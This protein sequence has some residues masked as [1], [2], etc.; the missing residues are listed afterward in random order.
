MVNKLRWGDWVICAAVL[1]LAGLAAIPFLFH[2]TSGAL[3]CEIRQENQVVQTIHLTE[4]YRQT[5]TLTGSGVTNVIEID[6]LQ[7]RFAQSSCPDQVCVRAGALTR[8]GQMAVCLPTRVTV[9]ILGADT[10]VDAI[11]A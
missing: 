3:I 6:G 11:A 9:R 7:V 2:H 8:A 5:V 1:C 4:G 10:Q